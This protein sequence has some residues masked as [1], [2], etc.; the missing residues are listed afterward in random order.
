MFPHG[1]PGSN[2]GRGVFLTY[3]K[4]KI[5]GGLKA[6]GFHNLFKHLDLISNNMSFHKSVNQKL[7]SLTSFEDTI[8][9]IDCL[10]D[11]IVHLLAKRSKYPVC[12]GY[13]ENSSQRMLE[14]HGIDT[15]W[16]GPVYSKIVGKVCKE[17]E[18]IGYNID[19]VVES[20]AQLERFVYERIMIGRKVAEYKK[21]DGIKRK[22]EQRE[23]EIIQNVRTGALAEGL[24][25]TAVEEIFR[26]LMAKNKHIQR[27]Y[28]HEKS[29]N[30][31]KIKSRRTEGE[32]SVQ[33]IKSEFRAEADRLT[34]QTGNNYHVV[35]EEEPGFGPISYEVQLLEE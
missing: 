8:N 22:R 1:C 32:V 7:E 30:L 11:L 21:P 2:P 4:S 29:D 28:A 5:F 26:F 15:V 24:N 19:Q 34:E 23:K 9:Y 12:K 20:E 14:E 18:V 35:V 16:W 3:Q 13:F 31:K 27:L 17:G 6:E 10:N 33:K 25:P